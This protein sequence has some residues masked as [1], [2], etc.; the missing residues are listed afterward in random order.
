MRLFNGPLDSAL[1]WVRF[2]GRPAAGRGGE[3][4]H[5]VLGMG[6]IEAT[7]KLQV[8]VRVSIQGSILGTYF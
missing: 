8:L 4:V 3:Q 7:R 5:A 6:R 2:C 1:R